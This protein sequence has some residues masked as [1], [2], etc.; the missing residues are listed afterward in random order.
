VTPR[1]KAP[2]AAELEAIAAAEAARM[3]AARREATRDREKALAMVLAD[4]IATVPLSDEARQRIA[5]HRTASTEDFSAEIEAAPA[6]I[7]AQINGLEPPKDLDD[8]GADQDCAPGAEGPPDE[9]EA[10]DEE[11]Q[12]GDFFDKGRGP[13]AGPRIWDAADLH[14]AEQPRWLARSRLPRAAL[15]LLLGDEGIGKSLFWALL[16]THI[17]TGKAFEGSGCR[18]ASPGWWCWCSPRTTGR[19]TCCHA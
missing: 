5:E 13:E 18:T 1:R 3:A 12:E 14:P 15:T 6:K 9:D 10:Q 16:A 17:S 2:G 4:V 7:N 19:P 8:D 11:Q